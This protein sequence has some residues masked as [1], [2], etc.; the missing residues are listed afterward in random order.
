MTVIKLYNQKED[1]LSD[2]NYEIN[3]NSGFCKKGE[4][5]Q[6]KRFRN[7]FAVVTG[8]NGDFGEFCA[9]KLAEEGCNVILWDLKSTE[10]LKNSLKKRYPNQLFES[11]QFN[12]CNEQEVIKH[13]NLIFSE[14][15]K[16]DILFNNAGYQGDFKNTTEYSTNDFQKVM[17]INV[18]GAFIVLREVANIM[19]KQEPQGGAIVN[20]AS[21]AGIGA[22]PNMIAYA[23]SKAAVKHMTVIASKDLSPFNIRVNSISPAFI[24]P[25]FMWTRQVELQAKAGSIYF[26]EDPNLVAKQMVNE[27]PMKRYGTIDEVIDPVL[28][29]LSD[30]SSY[31]TGTDIKITGGI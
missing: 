22:P 12:I 14:F 13:T 24:G 19:K 21:M 18:I 23:T 8:A 2:A 17:E 5:S 7:K 29:L 28:F 16:L 9:E 20:T 25:G 11:H 30:E 26:N 10:T 31:I 4:T 6:M 3:L 27:V 1:N 15:K